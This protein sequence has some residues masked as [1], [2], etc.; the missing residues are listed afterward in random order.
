MIEGVIVR[1][2]V[3]HTDERGFF[4]EVAR[5]EDFGIEAKQVSH[6]YR[7]TGIANGWHIH[8]QH[9]ELFYVPRGILRLCLKDCRTDKFTSV[10][11][12][13]DNLEQQGIV[14][15]LSSTPGEYNEV[16][17]GEFI[18][19]A[20]LVP[21]GVAHAYKVLSADCDIVYV[22]TATYET[23]K[24]DEGRIRWDYWKHD[25]TRSTEVR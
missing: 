19:K 13:Y 12:P 18:P 21:P 9:S 16:V 10:S 3:T 2:L 7:A 6:A 8:A 1:D 22:A 20:V 17:L 23:S 25:W 11:Y 14:F 5:F 4:R 15:G 24:H